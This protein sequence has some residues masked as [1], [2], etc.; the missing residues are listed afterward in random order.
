MSGTRNT[1]QNR[2]D[3]YGEHRTAFEKNAKKIYA[4]QT[5]CGICGRPVD[6]KLKFPHPMSKCIDHIIPV[7]KG[8]HP[9]DIDN[10]QLAHWSCNRAKSDKIYAAAK[11]PE[12]VV[13]NRDLPQSLDWK[14]YRFKRG[15]STH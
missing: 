2:P 11:S 9:S 12:I 1:P 14:T 15:A 3:R 13:N 6:F 5:V 10:L 4:S 7:A 8:G